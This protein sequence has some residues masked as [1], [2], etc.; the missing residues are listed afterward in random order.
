MA[1]EN[2]VMKKDVSQLDDSQLAEA[3]GGF[4]LGELFRRG[5]SLKHIH[6][7][8]GGTIYEKPPLPSCSLLLEVRREPQQP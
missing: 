1:E 5:K 3:N 7:G 2:E 6:K 8:C 4:D